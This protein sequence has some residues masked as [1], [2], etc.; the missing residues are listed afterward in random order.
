LASYRIKNPAK[1]VCGAV[2]TPGLRSVNLP[3]PGL[4]IF[5]PF[6]VGGLCGIRGDQLLHPVASRHHDFRRDPQP[7]A[8]YH[9]R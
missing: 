5:D 6:R 9:H 2:L 8:L 7:P 4:F 3:H 1:R